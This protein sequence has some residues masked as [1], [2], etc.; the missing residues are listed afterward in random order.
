MIHEPRH[1]QTFVVYNAV[2]E[3]EAVIGV[4]VG[5]VRFIEESIAITVELWVVAPVSFHV[6]TCQNGQHLHGWV[7][8][9][10]LRLAAAIDGGAVIAKVGAPLYV[11]ADVII[12]AISDVKV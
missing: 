2:S 7:I 9:V 1:A 10:G 8:A 3:V 12:P 5:R 6:R 4:F 11:A